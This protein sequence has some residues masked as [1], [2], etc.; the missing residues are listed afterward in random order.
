VLDGI[1]TIDSGG[2]VE[3]FNP[4]AGHIFGYEPAEVIGQN[5]TVLMPEP[6]RSEHD[7]YIANYVRTGKTKIIGT[8]LEVI[9]RRRDGSTFPIDLAVSE[10]QLGGRR[11]FVG[12]TRDI[13]E[14]K[15]A[16][17][18][19]RVAKDA[20]EQANHA[21]SQFLANMSHELRTPLNSIIGFANL[22]LRNK[23]NNLREQD[24]SFLSRIQANGTHLLTLIN[25]ILDL[26]KIEAG[27]T[28]IE[29]A[30]V[31]LD[32]L[33]ADIIGQLEGQARNRQVQLY[34]ALP[35]SMAL[36]DTDAAKLKQVLINLLGN[37]LKFTEQGRVTVQVDVD[38]A[39][40]RPVGIAVGDTGIGIPQDR[41]ATIF[42]A[43]QQ[44]DS[45]TTR[46]YGGTGLGLSISRS[47]CQL[48]GYRLEVSSEVGQGSTFRIDLTTSAEASPAHADVDRS[49]VVSPV[50][51]QSA[52]RAEIH[53]RG[54][55]HTDQ[56]VLVIDDELDA[57]IVLIHYIEDCGFRVIAA[58]SGEQG[59]RMAREFRPALITLDLMMPQMDGW[60]FLKHLR[61]DPEL[62]ET[63]VVV[64]SIVASEQ[65]GLNFGVVDLLDKPVTRAGLLDVLQRNLHVAGGKVL[66]VEDDVDAR[67]LIATYLAEERIENRQAP[68]GRKA[69]EMLESFVPD[70]VIL[71]LMMP[72]MDGMTFLEELRQDSRYLHLP[73]VVV[74]AKDLT[75]QE[76]QRLQMMASA[77]LKKGEALDEKLKE[78][79]R[80]LLQKQ[81]P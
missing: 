47:L 19:L 24:I 63:P 15:Q 38:P 60:E 2:I 33:I 55:K 17:E 37:A 14:R 53:R 9:G 49:P 7:S 58:N 56:L 59:L 78:V 35:P 23:A 10:L 32:R 40:R 45:S 27:R 44:V 1:I 54:P 3:S 46:K 75:A 61:A 79:L 11:M 42:E 69:L 41:L 73:V 67:R 34:A 62:R 64:V 65:R 30:P 52:R 70:L 13:I 43:F 28:E 39:T 68:N 72:V 29:M 18:A 21:K 80:S 66:V 22:L 50:L 25:D 4:A 16:E 76:D 77:V 36:L 6:Y 81:A 71:D 26:S 51:P 8:R 74:T 5:V 57:R 12:I 31:A 48:L 20:A